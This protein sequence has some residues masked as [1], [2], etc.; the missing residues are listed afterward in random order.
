MVTRRDRGDRA[1]RQSLMRPASYQ[2]LGREDARPQQPAEFIPREFMSALRA[3][4]QAAPQASTPQAEEPQAEPQASPQ[5]DAGGTPSATSARYD[6]SNPYVA[7]AMRLEEKYNLPKGVFLA[8]IQQ[9]SGFNPNAVSKAGA[10]GLAQLMPGTASDMG[11]D[12]RDPMQNLEGGARYLAEQRKRFGGDLS[13]AL[14]GYNAGPGA[15][16]K[17]GNAIPNFPETQKYVAAVM[18]NAGYPMSPPKLAD[19]GLIDLARKYADGGSVAGSAQVYDPAVIAAIAASIVEP[20]GYAEGGV[21]TGVSSDETA[22]VPEQVQ[23][24][25]TFADLVGR[26]GV[27]D[28]MQVAAPLDDQSLGAGVLRNIS[29]YVRPVIQGNFE[30]PGTVKKYAIDVATDPKPFTRLG[31]DIGTFGSNVWESVKE[32]PVETFFSVMPVSGALLSL[33]DMH[34][35]R[36]KAV[37]A[38]QAGDEDLASMYRQLSSVAV[39]G[40]VPLVGYAAVAAKR[41]ASM[42]RDAAARRAG[43]AGAKDAGTA[44]VVR[45]GVDD[46]GGGGGVGLIAREDAAAAARGTQAIARDVAE[47]VSSGTD[48]VAREGVGLEPSGSIARRAKAA[49]ARESAQA[50]AVV[51]RNLSPSGFYSLGEETAANLAQAKG[52]P[53][54]FRG[55]L[56][57]Y[58]VKPVEL[59]GFDEAFA[60]RPSVTREELAQH[61]SER[62]PQVE[63]TVLGGR[64]KP[65]MDDAA[66]QK[67]IE[68]A[69]A[70][71]AYNSGDLDEIRNWGGASDD[72]R[73]WHLDAA[74]S[75]FNEQMAVNP[76][77]ASQFQTIGQGGA[78][79]FQQ[80]TLPGG[81]NYREVL[82]RMPNPG[83]ALNA[84]RLEIE[85]IGAA[86]T[87][88]QR[89]EWSDIMNRLRPDSSDIEGVQKYKNFPE[90]RSSHW[91]DPNVLAHLR[92]SD[93]TG[94]NGEKIL[95]LEELQ[96]D[97]GQKGRTEGFGFAPGERE[98][99]EQKMRQLA[100]QRDQLRLSNTPEALTEA[101]AIQAQILQ[102]S[103]EGNTKL[104]GVP[105]APYVTNTAAWTDLALKRALKEAAEGGYDKIVW[106]P[107]AEQAKRYDLSKQIDELAYW[108]E[109]GNIGLS[110][111]GPNGTVFDQH[112]V[113]EKDLPGVVGREL[114]EEILKGKGS[115]KSTTGF[116]EEIGVN[117][118]SGEGLRVG[119][120]GMKAYYDKVVP[121][122][123]GKLVKKLDSEARIGRDAIQ[124]QDTPRS[125]AYFLDWA[126][127]RGDN[128]PRPTLGQVWQN[129]AN[130]PLVQ[131]FMKET[132]SLEVPSLT[133]TPKMREAITKGQTDFAEGGYVQGYADGG[134]ASGSASNSLADLYEKYYGEPTT[135]QRLPTYEEMG[136]N[137]VGYSSIYP[138]QYMSNQDP[139]VSP[140]ASRTLMSDAQRLGLLGRRGPV[141]GADLPAV[142]ARGQRMMD[143]A[144]TVAGAV[145]PVGIRAF[146]GSPHTFDRFDMAKLGTGEGAQSYGHG[147]YFAGNEGV[148]RSYRD[149]LSGSNRA[150]SGLTKDGKLMFKSALDDYYKTLASQ[151]GVSARQAR[152]IDGS[153]GAAHDAVLRGLPETAFSPGSM[154]EV[155][156]RTHPDRLLDWDKP[157]SVQ[158]ARVR[159]A[160][161]GNLRDPS[162]IAAPNIRR[163]T[164]K[165]MRG[166]I[167]DVDGGLAHVLVDGYKNPQKA[168]ETLRNAG[169]DGIQYLDGGSRAAGQGSSNYVMFDDKLIELL[170]RYGLL[171]MVGGGAAAAGGKQAPTEEQTDYAQG[172]SVDSVPVYDPAVIAAIAASITEDNYA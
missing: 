115:P 136:D 127:A 128:R 163:A 37:E 56:E 130:E 71:R 2:L 19:G 113:S 142:E 12:P 51:P 94:P 101:E 17:A 8:L 87:P 65:E 3:A 73:T 66:K 164:E 162:T 20:Q 28:A 96:S 172:G 1:E 5:Q 15:V 124:T 145:N 147:L 31:R 22:P 85:K 134:S 107:G 25:R 88:E 140:V 78:T 21:T 150:L 61:F 38:E 170:R 62:R 139:N 135:R 158:S 6:P 109:D 33:K 54:Q 103:R 53:Q 84:R 64:V 67:W 123:L 18:R 70:E 58:G 143:N 42:A 97:W 111:S 167:S 32:N 79:K 14:A 116:S 35:L 43:A 47:D 44:L 52:T 41:A 117:F 129:G 159:D 48:V 126:A 166:D 24:P 29:N 86:A 30:V 55:M 75:D 13:L 169:I 69:A 151:Y 45:G 133:I 90:F 171:G 99:S 26:Y 92:M 36:N 9:E 39:A 152:A 102:I 11:V 119:G 50:V 98:A 10:Y 81:E 114:A 160:I 104:D 157:L 63:E 148:A 122:Q 46:I 89:Q 155:N 125:M 112:Y 165:A 76:D 27:G 144:M 59:E 137:P 131:Q 161:M 57:K 74:R 132:S 153:G 110:A 138:P 83:D 93:R 91:D 23:A 40:A 141:T 156:L 34:E 108:R 16:I 168:A 121:N 146:H 95:H 49:A 154:Y 106:T 80:Y 7:E 60:G 72:I 149:K 82:L 100:D 77:F 105:P 118:I 120:E 68:D 4:A